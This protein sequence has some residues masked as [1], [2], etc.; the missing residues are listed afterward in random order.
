MTARVRTY[1]SVFGDRFDV[2]HF[3]LTLPIDVPWRSRILN[4][5]PQAAVASQLYVGIAQFIF[6]NLY[7]F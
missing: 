7:S 2:N 6:L 5:N 1:G 4:K 3:Q